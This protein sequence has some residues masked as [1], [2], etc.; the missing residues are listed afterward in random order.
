MAGSETIREFLVSLGFKTDEASLKKFTAGIEGATR[1]VFKLAAVIE[2]T[3]L[4]AAYGIDRFA[5]NMEQL[6]FASRRT[7]SSVT[8]L[9]ALDVSAQNF[10]AAAGEALSNVEAL[11]EKIRENPG[12]EGFLAGLGVQVKHL[13]D[14][15]VDAEDS[16]L[17]LMKVFQREPY[18]YAKQQAG[19]LGISDNM[20]RYLRDPGAMRDYLRVLHEIPPGFEQAAKDANRFETQV[21]DLKIVFEAF[22]AQVLDALQKKLGV[23]LKDV[24]AWLDQHGNEVADW[25]VK[26]ATATGHAAEDIVLAIGS[27][28]KAYDALLDKATAVGTWFAD[29]APVKLADMVGDSINEDLH[30]LG[31]ISEEDYQR[32]K[33]YYEQT[34]G[35]AKGGANNPGNL[36]FAGQAGATGGGRFANFSNPLAGLTALGRQLE[37]YGDRDHLNTISGIIGKYA[38][39]SDH[40]DTAGYIASVSK[41]LGLGAGAPLNLHDP[42]VLQGLI[43]AI[44]RQEGN[45]SGV[46][47]ELINQAA[48]AATRPYRAGGIADTGFGQWLTGL[49]NHVDAANVANHPTVVNNTTINVSGVGSPEQVAKRVQDAQARANSQT[50]RNVAA[51]VQ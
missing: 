38:P 8:A 50:V 13:K 45:S 17:Q 1:S 42:A 12:T 9:K 16:V 7:G 36:E 14:G 32:Q 3:A 46:T 22:G 34:Y 29:H 21:R 37:L 19:M 35:G 33:K 30:T 11:A 39:A 31:L 24:S 4:T 28:I 43:T 48:Q 25:V 5:A 18:Y 47:S 6:Y 40:N 15:T 44:T 10:G 49:A 23:S 20:L 41:S 2:A 51:P 27:I 26:A